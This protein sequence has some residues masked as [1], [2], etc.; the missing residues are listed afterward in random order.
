MAR[1]LLN[2]IRTSF[3]VVHAKQ[4][5]RFTPPPTFQKFEVVYVDE[6]GVPGYGVRLIMLVCH[7]LTTDL[8]GCR[9]HG[10]G[11]ANRRVDRLR[12][13]GYQAGGCIRRGL[14][15]SCHI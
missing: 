13:R 11:E 2:L 8:L 3:P 12:V 5:A 6:S 9:P 1:A 15:P 4:N 10:G 14:R 7:E